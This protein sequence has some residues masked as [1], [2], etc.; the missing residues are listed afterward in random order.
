MEKKIFTVQEAAELLGV[1]EMTVRRRIQAG[2]I[3]ATIISKKN[4]Y[5]ISYE[6]LISYAKTQPK[7][8]IFFTYKKSLLDFITVYA[9]DNILDSIFD[10]DCKP[11][12]RVTKALNDP[13]IIQKLIERLDLEVDDFDLK[14]EFQNFK[15]SKI[16]TDSDLYMLEMENLFK[17]KSQKSEILKKIKE[18]EIHKACI[19]QAIL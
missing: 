16:F 6:S 8:N 15:I 5:H 18:L 14:I 13:Y 10:N 19:E 12:E 2:L 1:S 11:D 17:L 4:G 9:D 7:T 3:E